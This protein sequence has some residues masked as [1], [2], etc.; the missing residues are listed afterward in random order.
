MLHGMMARPRAYLVAH[1]FRRHEEQHQRSAQTFAVVMGSLR[2]VEYLLAAEIFA[3]GD[4]DHFL[5]D[6]ALARPFEAPVTGWPSSPRS[7]ARGVLR[8]L[9]AKCLPDALP[10]STGLIGRPSYSS[11]PR[12]APSPM[13]CARASNPVS[14]SIATSLSV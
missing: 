1:E 4:V 2:D 10:L 5:G 14:T 6:D 8:K 7:Y 13:R 3:L 9:R 11:T 12:H